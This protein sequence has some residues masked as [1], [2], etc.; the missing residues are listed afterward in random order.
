MLKTTWE[1]SLPHQIQVKLFATYLCL[2][3]TALKA[4]PSAQLVVKFRTLT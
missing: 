1:K 4:S 3:M 2:W